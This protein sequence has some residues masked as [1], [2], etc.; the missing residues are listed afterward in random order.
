[1]SGRSRGNATDVAA[2]TIVLRANAL[3]AA[4]EDVYLKRGDV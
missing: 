2:G 4:I 3:L 1:M